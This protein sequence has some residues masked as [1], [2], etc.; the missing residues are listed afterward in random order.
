MQPVIMYLSEES[1]FGKNTDR[2]LGIHFP[3]DADV[4]GVVEKVLSTTNGVKSFY[5]YKDDFLQNFL[6]CYMKGAVPKDVN[7][8][9]RESIEAAF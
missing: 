6:V 1:T 3:K 9:V 7:A 4:K 8:A 5:D 2:F